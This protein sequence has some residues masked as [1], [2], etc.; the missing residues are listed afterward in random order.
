MNLDIAG[1][2]ASAGSACSSGSE[3]ESHVLEAINADKTRKVVRF[4]FSYM[5]TVKEA[6]AAAERFISI[7]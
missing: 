3:H 7:I 4:S 5:T 6:Q 2:C 1:I